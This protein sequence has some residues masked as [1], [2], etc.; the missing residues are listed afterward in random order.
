MGVVWPTPSVPVPGDGARKANSWAASA[1]GDGS[2]SEAGGRG[3]G[4]LGSRAL[5]AF[6]SEEGSTLSRKVASGE[7]RER[8]RS[9]GGG[10]DAPRV[11][12]GRVW[13]EGLTWGLSC[14]GE[15]R[16]WGDGAFSEGEGRWAAIAARRRSVQRR[17][18]SV[19][20]GP[21]G[22]RPVRAPPPAT[23]SRS[24]GG[25]WGKRAATGGSACEGGA[26]LVGAQGRSPARRAALEASS[27]RGAVGLG[28][29]AGSFS[30]DSSPP[31][32][33][34]PATLMRGGS[35]GG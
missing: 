8:A 19:R 15:M 9:R 30:S 28:L 20:G 25:P 11:R 33:S 13:V 10:S 14:G 2:R 29:G 3:P 23:G 1:G 31:E 21:P 12:E 5:A 32:G 18:R 24:K 17:A 26:E 34:R 4:G 6:R 27:L 35:A 16:A 22:R 7:P